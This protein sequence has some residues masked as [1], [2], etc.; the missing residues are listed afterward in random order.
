M[1]DNKITII[2]SLDIP[3][4]T[5]TI[6]N[7]LKTVTQNINAAKALK[8]IINADLSKTQTRIQS[9][10]NTIS[11]NLKL[12]INGINIKSNISQGAADGLKSMQNQ[13]QNTKSAIDSTSSS[14]VN[15]EEKFRTPIEIKLDN[16]RIVKDAQSAIQAVKAKFADLGNV[17]VK[18][19][20]SEKQISDKSVQSLDKMIVK[21]KSLTGDV[22]TLNFEL[23]KSE[24]RFELK[25]G[26]SDDAGIKKV[27][28]SAQKAQDKLK[29]LRTDLASMLKTVGQSY[30]DSN[31]S[32]P[33]LDDSHLKNLN[34]QYVHT[35][36]V[37]G[38]LRSADDS[39]MASMKANAEKE[40]DALRRM[41]KEYQNAEYAATTLR[42]KD[43]GTVK[44]DQQN[45]LDEFI[46]KINNSKVPI[47]TLK[48]DIN[49]LKTSLS[50]IGDASSFTSFLNQFDNVQ[51]KF[52]SLNALYKGIGDYEKQLNSLANT[53][54]KQGIYVGEVQKTIEGLKSS[55]FKVTTADGMTSWISGFESKIA[56]IKD[57]AVQL[58]AN[59][60]AQV[61][62]QNN[63]YKI[64]S[65]L[66]KLNP[67]QNVNEI[68]RLKE[69]LAI[70]E[71]TLANLQSQA[72]AFST[73][74]SIE[75]QEKYIAQ[76]TAKAK[77]K[78]FSATTKSED[79]TVKQRT[80]DLRKYKNEIDGT[81]KKL[82]NLYNNTVFGK[83]QNDS[84]VQSQRMAINSLISEYQQLKSTLQGNMTPEAFKQLGIS[85]DALKSKFDT[86][87]GEC[88]ELST[89]LKNINGAD[90]L[91]AKIQKLTADI[92]N[93]MKT[94]TR[95]MQS[96]AGM[97][98]VTYANQLR[99]M[100]N[101]L[102]GDVD[103]GTYN[104][105]AGNFN[106]IRAQVR[107]V[108]LEGETAFGALYASAK[109]FATWMGLT[110]VIS[111]F[112][113]S[114]KN[115]I[116]NVV[117]LDNAL[118]DLK[119]TFKG[120]ETDLANF[121]F[122]ANDTAKNLGVTTKEII[123]QASAWSRLGFSSA[124]AAETMAKNSAI[125]KTISPKMDMDTATDGL[126]SMMKAFD[127]EANDVL[128]GIMSKVNIVGNTFATDNL[129]IVE[130]MTRS[131]AA[132]AAA[133]NSLEETIALNTA[134]MEITRN[135]E[136]TANAWKTVSMRLRGKQILPPYSENC[137]LCA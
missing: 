82:N 47:E 10:L 40:I 94:N 57:Q 2:A 102:S 126:V 99:G 48:Q 134:S 24:N 88:G 80:D 34:A 69:K 50:S 35:L 20:F 52:K 30:L 14:L 108:G 12:D 53:W 4:S 109:K 118:V 9:Q 36:R 68:S 93:Y 137:M 113:R 130:A 83:N 15:L 101:Q 122:T 58:K 116:T 96:G 63:I 62:A 33:I 125:F 77:E 112:V 79:K 105:I 56:M 46:S 25:S 29:A 98:G 60:D 11:K 23:N 104:R 72:N 1:A 75:D 41:I 90:A 28:E 27:T 70:E 16:N 87:Q 71:K 81:L 106:T 73:L 120:T 44:I 64:Q 3:K 132:M 32:K 8:I 55:L 74:I 5:S 115:M 26:T 61:Q 85:L 129:S 103:Q 119:K 39:T 43:I 78:M 31:G 38:N 136:T 67:Q 97:G 21:V 133:N 92:Q 111:T 17:S 86:V 100:L 66:T 114:I 42:T 18:G 22:R 51:S 89:K 49:G 124:E 107:A 95:M 59:L 91:S 128:D 6:I 84:G 19:V 123:E 131:S 7:D 45:K 13:A 117:E 65:D 54:Q 127:I 110:T 121:Y 76:E 135:A 37:I